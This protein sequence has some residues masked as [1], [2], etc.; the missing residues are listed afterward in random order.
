MP[1]TS[2]AEDSA[3]SSWRCLNLIPPSA[4]LARVELMHSSTSPSSVAV[5]PDSFPV[6]PL[7]LD[8]TPTTTLAEPPPVV[9]VSGYTEL[10]AL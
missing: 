9:D 10:F 1:P 8:S 5:F 3:S 7:S 6:L 2:S 4:G